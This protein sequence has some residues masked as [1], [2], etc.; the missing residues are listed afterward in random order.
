MKRLTL[1]RH[2]KS[3]TD[4]P[5]GSDF[6]RSLNLRGRADARRMGQ[7]IRNLELRFDLVLASPARRVAETVAGVGGLSPQFDGRIY[8]AS[9]GQLLEIVQSVDDALER[10]ASRA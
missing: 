10:D 5:T 3:E 9:T 7:E 8:N 6:D 2:A 1:L 4:S